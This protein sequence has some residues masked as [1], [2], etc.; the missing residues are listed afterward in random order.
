MRDVPFPAEKAVVGLG[1][2]LPPYI[3]MGPFVIQTFSLVL[4]VAALVVERFLTVGG[5]RWDL[6]D[7]QLSDLFLYV[8]LG[9]LA[10][11][12]LLNQVAVPDLMWHPSTWLRLVPENLS[13][14][15]ACLGGMIA[16]NTF[17]R[18]R[19]GSFLEWGGWLVVGA[20]RFSSLAWLGLPWASTGIFSVQAAGFLLYLGLTLLLYWQYSNRDY[21]GQNFITFLLYASM[22]HFGL[23]IPLY[24]PPDAWVNS[25]QLTALFPFALGIWLLRLLPSSARRTQGNREEDAT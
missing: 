6:P 12:R 2:L 10:G 15:G 1:S 24:R 20:A 13:F 5:R 23:Q 11:A 3:E 16:L 4:V 25:G 21:P 9:S 19:G 17:V 22:L 14:L 18:R 7:G 8:A